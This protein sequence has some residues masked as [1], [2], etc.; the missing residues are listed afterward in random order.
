[1][2]QT[3]R[4]LDIVVIGAGLCGLASAIALSQAGHRVE[5]LESFSNLHE[6]GAGL[7]CTP[8]TAR[9]MK[10]WGLWEKLEP[11]AA[12][13]S[14]LQI[15]RFDGRLLARR[16]NYQ[17]E[18]EEHYGTALCG[19]HRV[20]LQLCLAERAL[21]VGASIRFGARV[22]DVDFQ[23]PSVTVEGEDEKVYADVVL[24]ADGLWS[25][26]RSK[27]LGCTCQ[28]LPTGRMAYRITVPLDNVPEPDLRQW[29]TE[30]RNNI[31]IGPDAHAVAYSVRQGTL[32][33]IV[34]LVKDDLPA[35][36]AKA[37]GDVEAMRLLFEGWDPV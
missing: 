13:M 18:V 15:Q 23:A 20:D 8:N 28:P 34:L 26:T 10:S 9:L 24:A 35:N 30:A 21:E 25:S 36:V 6:V 17:H 29:M 2:A 3:E 1:M 12:K 16:D 4:P 5:V 32:L 37:P 22:S 31:W 19:F 27:F 33:N 14:L 7:Q 11:H